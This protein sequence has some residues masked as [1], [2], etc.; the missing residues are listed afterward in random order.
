MKRVLADEEGAAAEVMVVDP[1]GRK[2]A[3]ACFWGVGH[4]LL[5]R[6]VEYGVDVAAGSPPVTR[7][8]SPATASARRAWLTSDRPR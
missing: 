3:L 1:G 8:S 5:D 7:A 4:G 6:G 2:F